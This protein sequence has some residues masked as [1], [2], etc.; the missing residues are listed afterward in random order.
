[1][2]TLEV[3]L[4]FP[5]DLLRFFYWVIFRPFTLRQILEH[6]DPPLISAMS[7][8]A[9]SWRTSYTRRS[10]TLLALFYIGLVPWLAAIG[11]GMVLAA[12]GAPMNWLTLAF[13]LLVGIALS[14]TFSL[15]FCVAFL[16]PFSLAVT[17]FSSSG[18]TLIHALL[19]SFGLGLAYS[20]TSKPAK[21]GLTA[22]LVYGAVF[23]L[24]DGP[25]PGLG[26]GASFLAGFFR[27]PLYL[28]E[29]PLTW[30]LASRASKVDASRLWSFQP[31]LWDELIWFPLPGLDIHLQALFRQDPALASQALISVRDSFRQ[32]WVVKSK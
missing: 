10:L 24:L 16:T 18:F 25:W 12:R 30:W 28:L 21:W 13:C 17:I 23:A 27:L 11:L 2:T 22:G 19:F 5:Q 4:R 29:A 20:L 1:V 7:L 31:F 26:I 32:G 14:L 8:F 3:S 9:R 15:G 6:L